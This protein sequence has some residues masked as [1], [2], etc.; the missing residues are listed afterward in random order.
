MS[1]TM[2]ISKLSGK[3]VY[4]A[5]VLAVSA[6]FVIGQRGG[7]SAPR[8]ERL[9]NGLKVLIWNDPSARLVTA[10]LRIHSGAAFDPQGKEGVMRMLA[11]SF[12]PTD[13]GR[14][15]FR[16]EL[17]GGLEIETNYDFVEFK[18]SS[19][20]DEFLTLL[21]SLSSAVTNPTLDK[22]AA[23][24]ARAIVLRQVE[25]ILEDPAYVADRAAAERLF[26]TFP[27]GR[28]EWG[29][30]E[31]L[32]KVDFAD[33]VFAYERFFGADNAT[34][35]ISGNIDGNLAYRAVRRHFGGWSKL[36]K[37][38]PHTF[39]QPD[40]PETSI[41]LVDSPVHGVAEV[42]YAVRGASRG[43]KDFVAYTVFSRIVYDRLVAKTSAEMRKNVFVRHRGHILPG[44]ILVGISNIPANKISD[45]AYGP[46]NRDSIAGAF[47]E[48]VTEAEFSAAK[49]SVRA[50]YG[51]WH[52]TELWLNADTY[53]IASVKAEQD[54]Y[55]GVTLADVQRAAERLRSMPMVS[56]RAFTPAEPR[57]AIDQ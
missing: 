34:L 28:P 9:L 2:K 46:V 37:R 48:P 49:A 44:I 56:V 11:E 39:R 7:S 45:G 54:A 25:A 36:Y 31:S 8:Q 12:F 13:I 52:V 42:R 3:I 40:V 51:G 33:L 4:V 57:S 21:E 19:T 1:Y 30:P 14:S 41:K 43:D 26:G 32:S 35:T 38:V 16:E 23:D 10:K 6:V 47:A 17:G 20:P 15:F 5:L 22:E 18:A 50:E 53:R 24:A 55:A 29:T 27:Y